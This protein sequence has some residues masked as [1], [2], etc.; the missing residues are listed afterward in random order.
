MRYDNV[1]ATVGSTPVVR[2]N[3]VDDTVADALWV[4]IESF[5]PGGS[6]KDRPA[7]NMIEDAERRAFSLRT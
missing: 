7:L 3:K 1:L 2:L 6:V 4:K 5:N